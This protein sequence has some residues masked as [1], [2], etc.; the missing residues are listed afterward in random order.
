MKK[1][2]TLQQSTLIV[3]L[4]TLLLLSVPLVAMQF[5]DEV[6]WSPFDF[7]IMGLLLFGTG[8]IYMLIL[9]YS[10]GFLYSVGATVAIGTTFLMIWANLAVGLIGDGPN[11]GNLMYFGVLA[12][13]I[14]GTALSHLTSKGMA[15][16]MYATAGALVLH[17]GI[18]LLSGMQD[19][20]HSSLE[21]IVGVNAFFATLFAVAG[22]LFQYAE[23]RRQEVS[24]AAE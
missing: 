9:R 19:Y 4:I 16:T 18:A 2:K 11:P 21:S 22:L 20:P 17:T 23:P 24:T 6:N 8:F 14:A 5:T 1:Q 7:V 15:R 10:P 12:T 3:G 13:I